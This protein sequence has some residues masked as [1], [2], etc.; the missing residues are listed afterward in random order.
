MPKVVFPK[1]SVRVALSK[2]WTKT[3]IANLS[4]ISTLTPVGYAMF[5]SHCNMSKDLVINKIMDTFGRKK[6]NTSKQV[7]IFL[8]R[9][10]E[11]GIDINLIE[12]EKPE[13]IKKKRRKVKPKKGDV[14]KAIEKLTPVLDLFNVNKKGTLDLI[15]AVGEDKTFSQEVIIES[16]KVLYLL[17]MA[18][19]KG[20]TVTKKT[21]GS[22]EFI[23]L[24]NGEYQK[25]LIKDTNGRQRVW[26]ETQSHLPDE[27]AF[28]GASVVM[29]VI[30]NMESGNQEYLSQ[31]EQEDRY[32]QYLAKVKQQQIAYGN[33]EYSD[34]DFTE[35]EIDE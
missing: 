9:C 30:Q 26:E 21:S 29:E 13:V 3:E 10:E 23:D 33:K 19:A 28:A 34:E 7:G 11:H 4:K 15:L 18:K 6:A 35:G 24:G 31:E 17:L 14:E 8:H 20:E 27:R 1:E 5:F 25:T 22:Y 16:Y 32:S 12:K 2:N